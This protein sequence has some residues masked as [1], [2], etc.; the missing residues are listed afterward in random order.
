MVLVV[1][2][3]QITSFTIRGRQ[4]STIIIVPEDLREL[5]VDAGQVGHNKSA[6]IKDLCLFVWHVWGKQIPVMVI[7]HTKGKCCDGNLRLV[8]RA[9]HCGHSHTLAVVCHI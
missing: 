4:P 9:A 3:W 8:L 5:D 7:K 2:F 6:I 1:E